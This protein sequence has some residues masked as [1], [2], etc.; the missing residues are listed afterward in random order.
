MFWLVY[1]GKL[2]VGDHA[3]K[4]TSMFFDFT[5]S[6]AA[7]ENPDKC[8]YLCVIKKITNEVGLLS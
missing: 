2:K 7:W 3:Y 8:S 4:L 5:L 6:G 1:I